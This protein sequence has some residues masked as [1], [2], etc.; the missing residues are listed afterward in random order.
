MRWPWFRRKRTSTPA[1]PP[2]RTVESAPISAHLP[3]PAPQDALLRFTMDY[4]RARRAR[5]RLEGSDVIAATLPDGSEVRYTTSIARARTDEGTSLLTIGSSAL[6]SVLEDVGEASR[7]LFLELTPQPDTEAVV[8]N[9]VGTASAGCGRCLARGSGA[10]NVQTMSLCT[11]CPLRAGKLALRLP[12]GARATTVTP[13]HDEIAVEY[14]YR[15]TGHDRSGRHD[16]WVRAAIGPSGRPTRPLDEVLL[17]T[18][19]RREHSPA[20]REAIRAAQ[21]AIEA[22]VQPILSATAELLRARSD[23]AYQRRVAETRA[24]FTRLRQERAQPAEEIDAALTRELAALAEVYSIEV[25]AVLES[26]CVVAS[27]VAEAHIAIQGVPTPVMLSVDLGRGEIIPPACAH[28][29][30]PVEA[31]A[32]CD[33]GHILCSSCVRT[34]ANGGEVLCPRCAVEV[35]RAEA[36]RAE[37]TREDVVCTLCGVSLCGNHAPTCASCGAVCCAAHLWLCADG[38]EAL[39]LDCVRQC[40]TCGA[41][42]CASHPHTCNTRVPALPNTAHSGRESERRVSR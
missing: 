33:H 18:A 19:R 7:L 11:T 5:V 41:L 27:P 15:I 39:C 32:V 2:T 21:P 24:T 31:G 10:E 12:A 4:L 3:P 8:E 16:A 20:M 14:T 17:P 30:R 28:C 13:A 38:G 35:T 9:I 25:E 40:E 22:H 6:S 42:T 29:Q 23:P 26:V 37:A 34:C 1:P 36:I